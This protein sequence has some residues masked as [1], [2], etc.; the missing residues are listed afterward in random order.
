MS[1]VSFVLTAVSTDS[2]VSAASSWSLRPAVTPK[3]PLDVGIAEIEPFFNS[4]QVWSFAQE[5]G[6]LK[7]LRCLFLTRMSLGGLHFKLTADLQSWGNGE[8]LAG[9]GTEVCWHLWLRRLGRGW[10]GDRR[11]LASD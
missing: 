1:E 10:G 9:R 5:T 7:P 8:L 2:G 4:K 11:P 6:T 3:T